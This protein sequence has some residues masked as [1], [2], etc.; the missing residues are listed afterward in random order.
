[1][2]AVV[3]SSFGDPASVL[4]V[5]ERPTPEPGPGQVRV[6]MTR[7]AIHNHDLWTIRGSYGQRPQLP[8]V[9]GTEGAGVVDAIG[10]GVTQLKVGDRVAAFGAGTWAEYYVSPAAG[11][12]KLPDNVSDDAGCQL[13]AMPL[14][15]LVLLETYA[16]DAPDWIV[17]NAANGAVG[18][19][20]AR[21]AKKRGKNVVNLVRN[22]AGVKELA[23]HG[24]EGA[25]DTSEADWREKVKALVGQ[26]KI[27]VAIDS[28]AGKASGDLALLLAPGGKLVA[29]GSM[30]GEPM[31]VEPG[32]F[33]F[34]QVVLEGFWLSKQNAPKPERWMA[35]TADLVKLV[36]DGTIDLP[37]AKTFTLDKAHDA[38]AASVATARGGKI[39]FSA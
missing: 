33:I 35:L 17:Q 5:G 9:A 6:K 3:Y 13:V 24:I 37:V 1:M 2:R 4:E 19:T 12:V 16:A 23:D 15:A 26:G 21:I 39:A 34:K 20:L 31:Q 36:A 30:S 32:P 29:F 22:A 38:V 14:S 25:I 7:A 11:A 27:R 18:K 28:V 8:A 10:E